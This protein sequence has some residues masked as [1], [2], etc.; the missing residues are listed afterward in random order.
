LPCHGDAVNT[1]LDR[2]CAWL[3]RHAVPYG[4]LSLQAPL[5]TNLNVLENLWLPHAWR[6]GTSRRALQQRLQELLQRSGPVAGDEMA[7]QDP[8]AWLQRRP[9][10]LSAAELEWA[11]VLRAALG[12][13][14][15]V[16]LDPGWPI[17]S[18][19]MSLLED[20]SW[21]RPSPAPDP[22]MEQQGWITMGA[23]AACGLLL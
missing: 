10:Q 1:E 17:S 19:T 11:V 18:V 12:R 22:W 9:S 23:A 20:A 2:L 21:W 7:A 14:R 5:L 15:V 13:P 8:Q 4:Y 3:G 16:V 6:A